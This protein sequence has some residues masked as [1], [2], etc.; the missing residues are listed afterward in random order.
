MSKLQIVYDASPEIE[1]IFRCVEQ[2]LNMKKEEKESF[3]MIQKII[4]A[5]FDDGRKF[6]KQILSNSS[7]KDSIAFKADI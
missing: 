7:V 4:Q 5:A 3:D 1:S 6:Q 2:H